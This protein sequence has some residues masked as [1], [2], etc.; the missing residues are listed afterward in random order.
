MKK[1]KTKIAHKAK[2]EREFEKDLKKVGS[3]IKEL[4]IKMG[5]TSYEIFAFDNNINRAQFGRY[6]R[7]EDLRVSS[8]LKILKA[9]NVS[10]AEFFNGL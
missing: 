4:R 3:R 10:P 2:K 6:E 1:P 5:Y 7:G 8:L 9:L